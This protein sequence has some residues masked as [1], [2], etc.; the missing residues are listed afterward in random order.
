MRKKAG[1]EEN[2]I[3][4]VSDLLDNL[5][6]D[7]KDNIEGICIDFFAGKKVSLKP[8]LIDVKEKEFVEWWSEGKIDKYEAIKFYMI[9]KI[10]DYLGEAY[11]K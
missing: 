7:E 1:I 8:D 4:R 2:K 11:T 6:E 3:L 9:D 5:D 10:F